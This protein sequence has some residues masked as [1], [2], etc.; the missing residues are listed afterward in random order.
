MLPIGRLNT[1]NSHEFST[2]VKTLQRSVGQTLTPLVAFG[3]GAPFTSL[4]F[5]QAVVQNFDA[6]QMT[7]TA[8]KQ[9]FH[10]QRANQVDH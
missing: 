9:A 1:H 3:V 5:T 7:V 8:L 4:Q 6:L 2:C 10:D